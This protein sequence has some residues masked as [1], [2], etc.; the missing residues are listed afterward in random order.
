M[1]WYTSLIVQD[2]ARPLADAFMKKYPFVK[3]E[4]VRLEGNEVVTKV[5]E[6]Y[7][8]NKFD[9]DFLEQSYPAIIG[10]KEAGILA[11]YGSPSLDGIPAEVRDPDGF[12]AA[13]RENPLGL[14][15]NTQQVPV[16]D[17]PKT[18]DDLLLPKW[19]GKLSTQ[20]TSQGIQA[21]GTML[22][23]KGE[24]YVKKLATQDV[25][26][27]DQSAR[28]V[29]ELVVAGEVAM[30]IPSSIGHVVLLKKTGAPVGWTAL[31]QATTALGY[32]ALLAKAPHPHA[33]MLFTDWML[34]EDG[35]KA[36][37]ATGEGAT[38]KG[39]PSE[40]GE[41]SNFKKFYTDLAMPQKEY[42]AAFKKWSDLQK[43][44]FTKRP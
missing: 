39:I 41:Y 25:Q 38:R 42:A 15:F 24:E 32:S 21:L 33:A 16:A 7:K 31:D 29:T 22:L 19:K 18:Y 34:G 5:T 8:A 17:A 9:A 36:M 4:I 14:A 20:T 30:T 35:Q 12:F 11:K 2:R 10:L 28:A 23:T 44:L 40:Y 1:L 43:A 27:Q 26:V 3:V 13:D 6:E 37:A